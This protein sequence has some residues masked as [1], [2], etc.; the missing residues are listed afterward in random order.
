M[1]TEKELTEEIRLAKL[2]SLVALGISVIN[3]IVIMFFT[4]SALAGRGIL[5]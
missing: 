1:L 4:M 2:A 5:L 3:I